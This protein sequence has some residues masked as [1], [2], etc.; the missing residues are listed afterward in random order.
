MKL[1]FV[2]C[3]FLLSSAGQAAARKTKPK[4]KIPV[5]K[6]EAWTFRGQSREQILEYNKFAKTLE[7]AKDPI[8]DLN[9]FKE[10][11][12][13]PL[14]VL[15]GFKKVPDY[16]ESNY[17]GPGGNPAVVF[18]KTLRADP[19]SDV[20]FESVFEAKDEKDEKTVNE[21]H[22]PFEESPTAVRGDELI[23]K[24]TLIGICKTEPR[25]VVIAVKTSG[26]YRVLPSKLED[27]TE[28]TIDSCA[29][30]KTAFPK[31]DSTCAEFTD[32]DSK[33][34]RVLLWQIPTS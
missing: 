13:L 24:T 29:A 2:L 19:P 21:W 15:E 32:L 31:S 1:F 17:E 26:D 25:P 4:I 23:F 10:E 12:G 27:T 8:A 5:C 22:L 33:S 7:D 34:K 30:K 9:R 6:D 14:Q 3:L 28:S 20:T 16:L 18:L 11:H